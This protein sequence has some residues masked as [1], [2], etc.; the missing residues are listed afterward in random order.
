MPPPPATRPRGQVVALLGAE[1]TGKTTLARELR[2][3]LAEEGHQVASVA[4]HLREFCD[5]HGRTPQ[6]DEQLAIAT[7]QTLRIGNAAAEHAFVIA[8]TT[9]LTIAVYS[10][11]I[12]G[13][14]ALY[15][16]ALSA[17]SGY[18][19]TL[20]AA[21]DIDWQPDGHQRDG[22]HVREPIDALLRAA[23]HQ[24]RLPFSVIY[25][26]GPARLQNALAAVR[27]AFKFETAQAMGTSAPRWQWV[28]ERCGDAQCERL[29]L[30]RP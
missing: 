7:E 15:A 8:D 5:Q 24:A 22:A 9:A 26:S 16:S 23:L 25:G 30:P 14:R 3:A 13:D 17:Q 29:L 20:L 4:E 27:S 10:D 21:P 11:F 19:L 6:R 18:A 28:C 12:F 1:S 2:D